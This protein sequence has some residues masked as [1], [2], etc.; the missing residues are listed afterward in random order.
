MV[1][2]VDTST[3]SSK[4]E[5]VRFIANQFRTFAEIALLPHGAWGT[6]GF[7]FW[8]FLSLLLARSNCSRILEL[9]SG[10]STITL[11]EYARFRPARFIS[12]ETSRRWFN[13]AR[14]ELRL[15]GVS[16]ASVHL[17][18][19]DSR[20]TWYDLEQFHATIRKDGSFDFAFIDGPGVGSDTRGIRDSKVALEETR[21]CI[22]EADV[23]IVDDVHRRHILDSMDAMLGEPSQYEKWFYDYS[24]IDAYLNTLCICVRKV[25][26]VNAELREIQSILDMPLYAT[27][28]SADCPED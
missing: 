8:T 28:K 9:G 26:P 18:G 20:E 4:R 6:K 15:L 21:R 25:S 11:A 16:D 14:L 10:R 22:Y 27:F 19:W 3:I 17:L 23:V 24:V 1:V 7:Q 12:I 13:K 2:M 5:R